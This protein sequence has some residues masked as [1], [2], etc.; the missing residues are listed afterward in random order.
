M[1]GMHPPS[2]FS[3][4]AGPHPDERLARA[5]SQWLHRGCGRELLLVEAMGQP[6]TP[7]R[8][9]RFGSMGELRIVEFY[10]VLYN[11]NGTLSTRQAT[12]V[13]AATRGAG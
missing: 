2:P 4:R 11:A 7:V 8:S 10:F 13:L 6:D 1:Q 3:L 12:P 9:L 5:W